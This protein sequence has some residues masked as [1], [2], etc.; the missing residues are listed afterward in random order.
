MIRKAELGD[1]QGIDRI[2]SAIH[3]EEEAGE[4]IVGWVRGLYPTA[5][6]A[7]AAI[8]KGEMFV[9][10]EEEILAAGIINQVQ[11]PSYKECAWRYPA[12]DSEVMVLHTLVVCPRARG[13]GLA[14]S[15]V[16]FYEDYAI[17]QGCRVLRMD[18][19]EKNLPARGLYA[20]LGFIEAGAVPCVF[21]GIPGVSLMMLEKKL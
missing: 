14:K 2:Y 21:N 13:R 18:T 17:K 10:E 7:E 9:I 8:L 20:S 1:V 4:G 6:T 12:E 5:A 16:R 11:V 15:F 19:Q 3:T